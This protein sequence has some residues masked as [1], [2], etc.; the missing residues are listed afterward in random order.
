[1]K[2]ANP[3]QFG[4]EVPGDYN[5]R[6]DQ[7]PW[8]E[9]AWMNKHKG[10]YYLQ[11]SGPGT[12][13]KSY[14][15]GV[16][17]SDS[18][19]GPYEA[20][21]HNPFAYRPEGYAAGAGHGST[22]KDRF[23][24]Y[25]HI[26]TITI[27][28]KHIF[29]RRLGLFPA[30]FDDNG[31][32]YCNTSFGDYPMILPQEKISNFEDVFPGWMLLSYGKKVTVSSSLD[33]LEASNMNDE[34]IRTYWSAKTGDKGEFAVMDLGES[35]EIRAIQIN[36]AEHNLRLDEIEKNA[37]H[38]FIVEHSIDSMNWMPLIDYSKNSSDQ[39]HMY[40]ALA[41]TTSAR[42]LRITNLEV[43][44]G[45]FAI[46]GFRVF[47]KGNGQL[48]QQ[49]NGLA[50]KR[51]LQDGRSVHLSWEKGIDVTGYNIRYGTNPELL[52]Q[53][54]QVYADTSVTINSLNA[55]APYF[56]SVEAFNESGRTSS[57]ALVS[58]D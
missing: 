1:L 32:L 52:Y 28:Q 20:Q 33:S 35:D 24:N 9:G 42:Y 14:S 53:N 22:F 11:Y 15:D 7:S 16:Y 29:E 8:I 43:P 18:P 25:W 54:Y 36:F 50:A 26:G 47:G 27:S 4:W 3:K 34:E 19:L 44:G 31:T 46:S 45:S 5:T 39:T 17:V 38:R 51:N 37:A 49:V 10:K 6:I 23:G 13:F 41:D 2:H 40:F 12:E 58:D 56:Y 30:F 48:P 55:D 57:K 21:K